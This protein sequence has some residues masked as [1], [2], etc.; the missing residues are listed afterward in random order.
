MSDY[1]FEAYDHDDFP[2]GAY[3]EERHQEIQ[4]KAAEWKQKWPNHC[5]SCWGNGGF[6]YG[7]RGPSYSCGG[8]P[9]GF[10]PCEKLPEGTCHRCGAADALEETPDKYDLKPCKICGWD[11]GRGLDDACPE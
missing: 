1:D 4:A 2:Y 10:D 5:Q 9:G 7:V 6:T 3:Y 8:E 11:S